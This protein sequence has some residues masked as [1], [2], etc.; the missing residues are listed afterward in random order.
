MARPMLKTMDSETTNE[1]EQT[2]F[3]MEWAVPTWL[4]FEPNLTLEEKNV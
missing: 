1:N 4:K 3:L 2:Q